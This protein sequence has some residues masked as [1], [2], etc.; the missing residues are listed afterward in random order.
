MKM[1]RVLC[2]PQHLGLTLYLLERTLSIDIRCIDVGILVAL[3]TAE[4]ILGARVSQ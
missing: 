4:N 2:G 1:I 3:K